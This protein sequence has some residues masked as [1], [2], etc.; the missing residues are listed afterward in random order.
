VGETADSASRPAAVAVRYRVGG[1]MRYL[2]HAETLRVFQRAC[3]RAAIPVRFSQGFN[4]H[5]RLSAPLPRSVAV[6][7][8]DECLLIRLDPPD[9]WGPEGLRDTIDAVLPPGFEVF[10]VE[11]A[12]A[13]TAWRPRSALYLFP[14]ELDLAGERADRLNARIASVLGRTS[15]VVER[16]AP[17]RRPPRRV[18]VRPF[19]M[20][21]RYGHGA[22]AL[23]CRITSAGTV[24]VDEMM[25]L[26][27]LK[28][29]D[30]AG[31]VRR[32]SVAWSRR[33]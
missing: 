30:L 15:L 32:V 25:Q 7:S 13:A 8:D 17:G 12:P 9:R 5:P 27:E 26:F 22:L 16:Q 31:P 6:A 4:P 19:L 23:R 24:R 10:A 14:L 3:A 20:A 29:E 33:A 11:P 18:D 21:A 28:T 1:L 2:S